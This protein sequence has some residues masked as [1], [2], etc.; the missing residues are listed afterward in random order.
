MLLWRWNRLD[1][2][3]IFAFSVTSCDLQM[4][5]SRAEDPGKPRRTVRRRRRVLRLFRR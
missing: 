1:G 2:G 5:E 4:S 3:Y